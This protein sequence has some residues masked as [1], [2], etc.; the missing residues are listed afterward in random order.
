MNFLK[1]NLTKLICFFTLVFSLNIIFVKTSYSNEWWHSKIANPY[2]IGEGVLKVFIWDVYILR[3]FSETKSFNLNQPI[4]LEFEYLRDISKKSVIK[5]SMEELRK[6]NI[7]KGK[8]LIWKKHLKDAISDMK[9]GEK[10]ALFWEPSKQITFY[11]KGG[12]EKLIEDKEFADAYINIWIGE[13]TSR[14]KLRKR[15]IG[16]IK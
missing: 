10:A 6:K 4:V 7:S 9:K 16:L 8:L 14:P 2:L 15:I 1:R 11:V 12:L 5:A 13:N 3:L